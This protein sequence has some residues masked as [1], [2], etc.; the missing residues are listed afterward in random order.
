MGY[1]PNRP[2]LSTET[3]GWSC[4]QIPRSGL[5]QAPAK[6][7]SSALGMLS[8]LGVQVPCPT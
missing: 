1:K 5:V 6:R 4:Y 7:V 8:S 2:A 3:F